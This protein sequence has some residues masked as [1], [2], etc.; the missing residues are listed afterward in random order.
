MTHTTTRTLLNTTP[1]SNHKTTRDTAPKTV[2]RARA[3]TIPNTKRLKRPSRGLV[4]IYNSFRE[5][6]PVFQVSTRSLAAA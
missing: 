1:L 2:T 3:T 6:S 5:Y 4:R